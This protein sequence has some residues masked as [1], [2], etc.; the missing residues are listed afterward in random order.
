[1]VSMR[2]PHGQADPRRA[3]QMKLVSREVWKLLVDSYGANDPEGLS[4]TGCELCCR[5]V[6][7]AHSAE[8]DEEDAA[9]QLDALLEQ[10]A[11][12]CDL[13]YGL[14]KSL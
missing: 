4:A 5:S 8:R 9:A 3:S 14:E 7:A 10:D 11:T 13:R 12:A 6:L 2:C 1:M